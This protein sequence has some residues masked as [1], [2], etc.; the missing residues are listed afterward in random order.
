MGMRLMETRIPKYDDE[1]IT[2]IRDKIE[3]VFGRVSMWDD[4][5]IVEKYNLTPEGDLIMILR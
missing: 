3:E 2:R 5:T 1:K 4:A